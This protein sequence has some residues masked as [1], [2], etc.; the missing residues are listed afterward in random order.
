MSS[1]LI[2]AHCDILPLTYRHDLRRPTLYGLMLL[3]PPVLVLNAVAGLVGITYSKQGRCIRSYATSD[4][5]LP[6]CSTISHSANNHNPEL[7]E[8]LGSIR[9]KSSWRSG[10]YLHRPLPTQPRVFLRLLRHP[11]QISW[12]WRRRHTRFQVDSIRAHLGSCRELDGIGHDLGRRLW[13]LAHPCPPNHS[14]GCARSVVHRLRVWV[15]TLGRA[16]RPRRWH[17]QLTSLRLFS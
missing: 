16:H 17:S 15:S 14:T 12:C 10:Q 13:I 9:A 6:S 4:R 7:R 11:G 3:F 2:L 8:L 5:I 1:I